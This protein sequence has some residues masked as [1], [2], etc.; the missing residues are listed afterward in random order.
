MYLYVLYILK[1]LED[2]IRRNPMSLTNSSKVLLSAWV[3]N[4]INHDADSY[5]IKELMATN[6]QI[7]LLHCL[8]LCYLPAELC[9]IHTGASGF[10]MALSFGPNFWPGWCV[11][12]QATWGGL[13]VLN[14]VRKTL[15]MTK[16]RF[17]VLFSLVV[18]NKVFQQ[19]CNC[20]S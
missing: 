20:I 13:G 1:M 3:S 18:A 11:V 8:S 4:A 19:Y 6:R 12:A 15:V 16:V 2:A 9:L 5:L 7:S 17:V 10:T 14:P